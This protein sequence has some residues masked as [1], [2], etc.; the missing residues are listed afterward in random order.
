[1]VGGEMALPAG[2]Q[3]G[4]WALPLNPKS[5]NQAVIVSHELGPSLESHCNKKASR[6]KLC[7]TS[8]N[9]RSE[10]RILPDLGIALSWKK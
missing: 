9:T 7:E 5:M 8:I 2:H 4:G 6:K 10:R 3:A 1:M